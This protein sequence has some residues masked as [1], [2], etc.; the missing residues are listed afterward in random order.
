ML[1]QRALPQLSRFDSGDYFMKKE[2]KARAAAGVVGVE[3]PQ[4]RQPDEVQGGHKATASF[5]LE[6]RREKGNSH[7]R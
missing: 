2:A 5:L 3:R 1:Q 7:L 6:Q 4:A